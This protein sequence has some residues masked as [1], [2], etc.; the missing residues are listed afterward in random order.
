MLYF[1]RCAQEDCIVRWVNGITNV[2]YMNEIEHDVPGKT[3]SLGSEIKMFYRKKWYY[4]KVI[5][6]ECDEP[7]EKKKKR[8]VH[9]QPRPHQNMVTQT[10][11]IRAAKLMVANWKFLRHVPITAICA[12]P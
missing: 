3:I 4:G 10:T 12:P 7:T 2:V 5:E 1:Y 6:M 9:Q 8:I 11:L